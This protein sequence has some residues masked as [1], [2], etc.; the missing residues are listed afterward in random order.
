[1]ECVLITAPGRRFSFSGSLLLQGLSFALFAAPLHALV[2]QGSNPG[3]WFGTLLGAG[4]S[5]LMLNQYRWASLGRNGRIVGRTLFGRDAVDSR[6]CALGIAI[7]TGSKGGSTYTIYATDGTSRIEFA[8]CWTRRG[9]ESALRR[10][11]ACFGVDHRDAA[12][13]S[14]CTRIDSERQRLEAS[15]SSAQRHVDAYYQSGAFRRAGYLVV[16]FIVLYVVGISVYAWLTH[17]KL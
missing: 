12:R 7:T 10:L 11:E 9:A 8:E 14:A 2:T 5:S 16:G 1:M 17:T 13:R 3:A 4:L 6:T 15:V